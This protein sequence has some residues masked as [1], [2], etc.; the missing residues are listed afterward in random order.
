MDSWLARCC[1]SIFLFWLPL[2]EPLAHLAR[3][4]LPPCLH[5]PVCFPVPCLRSRFWRHG[6]TRVLDRQ[7]SC[8]FLL[9]L[10]EAIPLVFSSRTGS[11]C[12]GNEA[13]K[14]S[15][16]MSELAKHACLV[17]HVDQGNRALIGL[18]EKEQKKRT[19][20]WERHG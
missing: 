17:T 6:A 13:A 4:V 10:I 16:V 3:T 5:L 19:K 9:S 18:D 1:L 15:T 12:V 14:R 20:E 2:L 11:R 8:L 7:R